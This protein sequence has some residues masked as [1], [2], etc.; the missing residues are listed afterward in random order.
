MADVTFTGYAARFASA[1][2]RI[3]R[4]VEPSGLMLSWSPAI[5]EKRRLPG[6]GSKRAAEA[7]I[8][9]LSLSGAR[10]MVVENDQLHRG[11]Q[12]AIGLDGG[13]GTASVR[14]IEPA[15]ANRSVYGIQFL[16]LDA[17][18]R[19]VVNRLVAEARAQPGA[20]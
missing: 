15:P 20:N 3:G 8:L 11:C 9:D 18:L 12:V 7:E 5:R 16:E 17:R 19:E 2:R 10:V 14:R 1:D 13:R 4:R 6:R